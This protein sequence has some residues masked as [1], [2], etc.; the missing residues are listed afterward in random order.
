MFPKKLFSILLIIVMGLTLLPVST[1]ALTTI[2][3]KPTSSNILLNGTKAAIEGYNINN[4]NYFKLRDLAEAL[5]GGAK[6]FEVTW[7]GSKNVINILTKQSYTSVGGELMIPEKT[8]TGNA[9]LS[10]SKLCIDGMETSLTA[11][12]ING[13]NYFKLRDIGTAIDFQVA[14]D[15][16]A[17]AVMINTE[18]IQYENTQYGFRFTL[19]ESWKKY[20]ILTD[21]WKGNRITDQ[22]SNS[23][24]ET[25]PMIEIRHP[26]W[27]SQNPRQDIP[28]MIVTLDQWSQIQNEELLVGAGP[29]PPSEL[30]RNSKYVFAL[31]ARYNYAFPEGSEEVEVILEHHPLQ[32]IQGS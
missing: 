15:E 1:F 22:S 20:S 24:S 11:Y 26:Q 30:G 13:N 31:P 19:P 6:Q 8:S 32:P 29:I 14:Y 5:N 27:T 21:E 3:A 7:D 28:I 16:M 9:V 25:G 18:S 2:Q 12:R 23:V 10:D 4:N 17:K